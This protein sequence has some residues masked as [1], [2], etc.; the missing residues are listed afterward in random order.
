MK[1]KTLYLN[2]LA[3]VLLGTGTAQASTL[4]QAIRLQTQDASATIQAQ[5]R[6]GLKEMPLVVHVPGVSVGE[7]RVV[8]TLPAEDAKPRPA[9]QTT[10]GTEPLGEA[11]RLDLVAKALKVPGMFGVYRYMAETALDVAV[12]VAK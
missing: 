9:L 4:E 5:Q 12:I 7:I 1:R 3:A 11:L 10:A 8:K 6:A 2:L